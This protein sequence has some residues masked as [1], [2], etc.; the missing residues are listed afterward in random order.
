[1][2]GTVSAVVVAFS[3][4]DG[5]RRAAESLLAQS[6]PP[7]EVLIVDNHPAG[8]T[9]GALPDWG[10][11]ERVR[12]VHSGANLGYA[13]GCNRAA[14]QAAG[15]W[16]LFL[17]PD[18]R[19]EPGC[20]AA[21][22][23]AAGAEVGVV[24]AQVLLEDGRV[25]AGANPLHITGLAWAGRYGE[26]AEHGPARS[27]GAVSGAALMARASAFAALGGLCE[28]FFMYQ[29]DADLCWRMRLAGWEVRFCPEALVRH[30]YTFEKGTDKWYLLE[31]NRLW[32]VLSNYSVLTLL[33]LAPVLL[34]GEAAV[35]ARAAHDGW[36]GAFARAWGSIARGLPSVIRWRRRVQA[37]RRVG[38]AEV[39]TVMT[40]RFE[41]PLLHSPAA[42]NASG[43]VECYRR[44]VLRVLRAAGG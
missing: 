15:E 6:E 4:A 1:M 42:V 13:A 8:L 32:S 28:P 29:D 10:L 9:A 39:L 33:A 5:A 18:A 36:L 31:R 38:D 7:A 3:D 19:A 27:A 34:A 20:V 14:A 40:G 17:N 43:L 22:L 25:N 37:S 16:L 2:P 30:D 41:T 35:A 21:L 11:G 12:L 26:A 44:L 24:G 23:A